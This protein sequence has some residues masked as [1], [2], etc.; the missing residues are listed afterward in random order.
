MLTVKERCT[1]MSSE[2]M[3]IQN[4]KQLPTLKQ[5]DKVIRGGKNVDC[6]SSSVWVRDRERERW[7]ENKQDCWAVTHFHIEVKSL[8]HFIKGPTWDL[9]K[10][11]PSSGKNSWSSFCCAES[12][13]S[14]I[15]RAPQLVLHWE[16]TARI[17]ANTESHVLLQKSTRAT[18]IWCCACVPK[19]GSSHFQV[20]LWANK[21]SIWW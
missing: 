11:I 15:L 3:L 20:T 5:Q 4:Q 18:T 7:K 1:A 16:I 21:R 2:A 10:T 17:K 6:T 13:R 8:I 19:R 9:H 12:R 14:G